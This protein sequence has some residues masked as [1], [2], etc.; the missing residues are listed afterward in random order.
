VH[1][2]K[3]H[4]SLFSPRKTRPPNSFESRQLRKIRGKKLGLPAWESV[5]ITREGANS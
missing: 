1:P 3:R 2:L 4:G 5:D